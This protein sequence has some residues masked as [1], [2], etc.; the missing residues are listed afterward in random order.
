[1]KTI[2]WSA[3]SIKY[4]LSIFKTKCCWTQVYAIPI[5]FKSWEVYTKAGVE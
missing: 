3:L 1:M 2:T 4:S 5:D